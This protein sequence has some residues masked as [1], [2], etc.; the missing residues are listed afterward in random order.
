M[1]VGDVVRLKSEHHPMTIVGSP[2]PGQFLCAWFSAKTDEYKTHT[3]K[4][5]ALV[6]TQPNKS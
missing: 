4:E 5:A 1:N 6:E 3:F 2:N